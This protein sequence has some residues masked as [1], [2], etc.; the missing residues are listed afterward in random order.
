MTKQP[1]EITTTWIASKGLDHT[2]LSAIA[3]GL[4]GVRLIMK[5]NQK[6]LK[7]SIS[8]FC[9]DVRNIVPNFKIMIDLPGSKPRLGNF[10]RPIA[11]KQGESI[12][13]AFGATPVSDRLVPSEYLFPYRSSVKIGDRLLVNDG[14][15]TF[16]ISDIFD[17]YIVLQL[18]DLTAILT[19]NRSINLPDS[20]VS[21][22][23]LTPFDIESLELLSGLHIDMVAL[24]MVTNSF[25][26]ERVRSALSSI[27]LLSEII[28]KIETPEALSDINN[29]AEQADALM[30]A[31]GDMTT[32]CGADNL[33][34]AQEAVIQ[35][36]LTCHKSVISATGLLTSLAESDEP[37]ISEL[38]DVGYLL[39]RGVRRFLLSD[40]SLSLGHPNRACR[41]LNSLD[42]RP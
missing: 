33:F 16:R 34:S 25:D 6:E 39:E 21:F 4:S 37:S 40:A 17:D 8:K 27:G 30:I 10:A 15:T 12:A 35:A 2:L 11:L 42:G 19:P 18:V 28:A 20:Q 13:L 22:E 9:R 26:I 7:L 36:G 41:W 24:S 31:R 32:L 1:L 3:A 38:C 23:A 14:S 29:I 5:G